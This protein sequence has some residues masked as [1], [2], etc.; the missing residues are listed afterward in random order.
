MEG[1]GLLAL[2]I[3]VGIVF[4]Y[5]GYGK[6]L[7]HPEMALGMFTGLGFPMPLFWT[8]FVGMAEVV[9]GLMVLFGIFTRVAAS[10]LAIVMV[11]AMAT[12]HRGGPFTGYFLPLVILGSC[13]ALVGVGAGKLRLVRPECPC[14]TCRK[15]CSEDMKE[16]G[17]TCGKGGMC[18]CGKNEQTESCCGN[19]GV[20]CKDKSMNSK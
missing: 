10:W 3:A 2:R 4:I 6:L 20:C 8:Y 19:N 16:G 17:C 11:V 9:G 1:L 5:Q 13:L 14:S 18:S 12:A 15:G 7:G